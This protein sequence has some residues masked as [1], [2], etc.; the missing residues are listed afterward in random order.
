MTTQP[1]EADGS[2]PQALRDLEDAVSRLVEPEYKMAGSPACGGCHNEDCDTDCLEHTCRGHL[3]PTQSLYMQ[4]WDAVSGQQLQS[5]GGGGSKSRPPFDTDAFDVLDNIDQVVEIWQPAYT[6]VP[7]TVGRLRTML[8]CGYRPQDV[9]A[10]EQKVA[11]LK[12][13][14]VEIVEKLTP[15]PRWTLPNPCPACSK[16]VVYRK[17]S[18]GDPIRQPALQIGPS[19]CHCLNCHTV[20][21]P[22]KFVFLA[23]VLGTMPANV[24]E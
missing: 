8:T 12:E 16:A 3:T 17:D 19:G 1:V 23:K 22:E 24:L 5:G 7:A 15:A 21:V 4:L 14:A 2:L 9:H 20:W 18:A 10:L 11:I 6:G 13:W